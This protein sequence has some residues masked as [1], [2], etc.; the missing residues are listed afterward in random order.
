M[1]RE[2]FGL[3]KARHLAQER[4]SG[5]RVNRLNRRPANS[6]M[7]RPGRRLALTIVLLPESQI[8]VK[9]GWRMRFYNS[10]AMPGAGHSYFQ[11]ALDHNASVGQIVETVLLQ[12]CQGLGAFCSRLQPDI[13]PAQ[14]Q[15]LP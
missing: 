15:A 13:H 3:C 5:D 8:I 11:T 9:Q 14:L 1:E 10:R 12:K 7:D 2:M 4:S 6:C